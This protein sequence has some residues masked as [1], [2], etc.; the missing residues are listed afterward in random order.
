[1]LLQIRSRIGQI[2]VPA[3]N[4]GSVCDPSMKLMLAEIGLRNVAEVGCF[5]RFS[6]DG[7]AFVSLP[8]F[9]EH[10]DLDI[11]SKQSVYIEVSGRK[12]LFLADS[13]ALD[14][15]MYQRIAQHISCRKVDALFLGM[16]CDG[17]P[18]TWLYGPLLSRPI[19]RRDDESRRLSGANFSR[20]RQIIE[21]FECERVFVYAMGL[22]PWL[23]YVMGVEL[24]A[25]SIQL[26]E[27]DRLIAHLQDEGIQC[28]R[29]YGSCDL[30]F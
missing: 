28:R 2:V 21:Q 7:G 29:L 9:G 1:M 6:F 12:F 14:A 5:A 23:R 25:D 26:T 17:A 4:R 27:S 3:C 20:A 15:R 16:E 10:A 30:S 13:D 19:S 8:F 11:Y 22:E 18:L 24:T